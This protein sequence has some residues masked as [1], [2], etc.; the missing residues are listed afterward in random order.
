V[1]FRH[2]VFHIVFIDVMCVSHYSEGMTQ[3]S[4]NKMDPARTVLELFAMPCKS[5]VTIVSAELGLDPSTVYRWQLPKHLH[6]HGGKVPGKHYAA[7]KKLAKKRGVKLPWEILTG[8]AF[9]EK[10]TA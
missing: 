3:K 1:C 4:D 7:L 2:F 9:E 8:E 6:G 10:G 5:G